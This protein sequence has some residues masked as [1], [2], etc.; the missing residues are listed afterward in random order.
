MC[1]LEEDPSLVTVSSTVSEDEPVAVETL[2]RRT[3][4]SANTAVCLTVPETVTPCGVASAPVSSAGRWPTRPCI[5]ATPSSSSAGGPK[6][7]GPQVVRSPP[8]NVRSQPRPSGSYEPGPAK[9]VEDSQARGTP[10]KL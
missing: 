8:P 2:L 5:P 7:P 1:G 6:L 9:P 10:S 3:R 4:F